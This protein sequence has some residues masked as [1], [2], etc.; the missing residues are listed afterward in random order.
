MNKTM[1]CEYCGGYGM[2]GHAFIGGEV[3]EI[4]CTVCNGTG[5]APV[6]HD[7]D[8]FIISLHARI[9]ELEAQ[10]AKLVAALKPFSELAH[11]A[12]DADGVAMSNE[13]P[14]AQFRD[15]PLYYFDDVVKEYFPAERDD[16][17]QTVTWVDCANAKAALEGVSE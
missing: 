12:L 6:V 1:V 9:A 14:H 8:T 3:D 10:N 5:Q 16:N 4:T 7:T 15:M 11:L 2:T 17:S 13:I